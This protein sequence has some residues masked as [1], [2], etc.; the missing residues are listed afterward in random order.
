MKTTKTLNVSP[1]LHRIVKV[2]AAQRGWN[3]G[4]YCNAVIEVGLIHSEEVTKIMETT[5][6]VTSET[7]EIEVSQNGT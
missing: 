5:R 4:E 7:T 2:N 1:A 3:I 6:N